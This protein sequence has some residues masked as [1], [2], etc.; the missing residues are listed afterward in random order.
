MPAVQQTA[1]CCGSR[2]VAKALGA[3]VGLRNIRGIGICIFVESSST[4]A[5][6][7]GACSRVT[8]CAPIDRRASL[9]LLK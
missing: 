1:A 6:I 7:S 3:A 2:P 4:M 9:S 8:G 5:Y